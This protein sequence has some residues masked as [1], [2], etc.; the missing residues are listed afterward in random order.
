[1]F[2]SHKT[3]GIGYHAINAKTKRINSHNH[4]IKKGTTKR[5][6]NIDANGAAYAIAINLTGKNVAGNNG[7]HHQHK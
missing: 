6:Q 3:C 2:R 7:C 1:M 5:R 4:Q